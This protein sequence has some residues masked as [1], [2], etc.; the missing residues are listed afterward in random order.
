MGGWVGDNR[1]VFTISVVLIVSSVD[2]TFL[3]FWGFNPIIQVYHHNP[4][5]PPHVAILIGPGIDHEFA[6]WAPTLQLLLTRRTPTAITG[7]DP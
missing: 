4:P 3:T 6:S 2:F 7:Y 5:P 1:I